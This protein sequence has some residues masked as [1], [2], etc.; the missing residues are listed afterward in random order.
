[1]SL[2]TFR[3]EI[4]Q[5]SSSSETKMGCAWNGIGMGIVQFSNQF[6]P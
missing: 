5:E 3:P 1:L 2:I 6:R 4:E